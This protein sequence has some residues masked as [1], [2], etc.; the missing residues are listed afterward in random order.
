MKGPIIIVIRMHDGVTHNLLVDC[1]TVGV[2]GRIST[3]MCRSNHEPYKNDPRSLQASNGTIMLQK[4][5]QQIA[6]SVVAERVERVHA[7]G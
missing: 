2:E 4:K 6:D 3:V 7:R 5:S 1:R